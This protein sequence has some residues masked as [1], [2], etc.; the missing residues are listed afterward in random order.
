MKSSTQSG[1]WLRQQLYRDLA[2]G[3]S[4]DD[5]GGGGGG[6]GISLCAIGFDVSDTPQQQQ[7]QLTTKKQRSSKL[8]RAPPTQSAPSFISLLRRAPT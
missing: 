6:D 3:E 4:I 5:G 1:C 8:R 2:A 7:Q